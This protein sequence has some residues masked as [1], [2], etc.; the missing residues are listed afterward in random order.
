MVHVESKVRCTSSHGQ[1]HLVEAKI[2]DTG[3]ETRRVAYLALQ[4]ID[5][6]ARIFESGRSA[7]VVL[8]VERYFASDA[9][10]IVKAALGPGTF[11]DCKES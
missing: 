2:F 5:A 11:R 1:E 8:K 6:N 3:S 7:R 10:G 9:V 4:K